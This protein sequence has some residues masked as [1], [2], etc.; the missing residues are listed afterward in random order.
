MMVQMMA[1]QEFIEE[2]QTIYLEDI[3]EGNPQAFTRKRKTTP[4]A[5]ML[6][7]FAQKGNSQ[8]CELLNFYENLGKPLD[9]STV[10][11]YKARM[12]YNPKAIRLMM[13]D[14]MSMVYEEN[15]DQLVKLNGYIVTAI[16][17]SD[18]ILPSTEENTTKY[19]M[20]HN[21]QASANPVMAS[22]SILYDCINK[23]VI[24]TFVG[25]YKSSERDSASQ[26]L[27]VLKETLR[28]PTITVFDRGYFSMRLVHQ[29]NQ[30]GQKFVMRM[31]HRN[32]KRYSS[33]LSAG[34][35]KSFEVTFTR[36]QT[37]YYRN[38]RIFRATLMNTVYPLR[39]VKIPLRKQDSGKIEDE[40]LLTNLTPA[41][42]SA[43]DL[44]EVYRLRWGIE[45]A[46]NI[47]KNRMK[48]E[49]FSGIR[50]RLIL[51]DIYC[52]VWLYNLTMLHLIEVSETREIP[53]ERYK[54]EMKQNI[55]IAIG[56]VKTYF[57]ESIMG[58]TREQRNESFEHMSALLTK[59]LVPVRPHRAAKRK[60]P[61]NKSRRSYRY[62]Y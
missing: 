60:N 62:T 57:I 17:G 22:V 33:Q 41:E 52:S 30:D 50:E 34:Q 19:G 16:D 47:L 23:L 36:S 42:F 44:N 2:A 53:Q 27:H 18:I 26:H 37:N 58:E 46:Y 1:F 32:L 5:L 15:D 45:T 8:F 21:P 29:L 10:A 48:L 9:I 40:V 49:E 12:N 6:Q 24:D 3:R 39:F 38:D 11:F 7:M 51:Q 31:N 61:V 55:S 4:L 35:D 59:H 28:Q 20:S 13:T 56:I 25:P 54:Y 43:D 14:Y